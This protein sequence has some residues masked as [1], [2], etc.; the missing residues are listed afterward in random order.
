MALSDDQGFVDLKADYHFQ[1]QHLSLIIAKNNQTLNIL[2]PNL[3]ES[4]GFNILH[5]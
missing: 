2:T 1:Q 3:Q 4:E 5:V